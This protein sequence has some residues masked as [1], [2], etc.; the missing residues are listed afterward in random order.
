M[1]HAA[2]ASLKGCT[3][4]RLRRL[5]RRVTQH[6]D[7]WLAEA[8]LRVTQY[9]LLSMLVWSDGPTLSQLA[10]QMD[11]DRTTLTRNLRPLEAAG[12]VQLLPD[13]H[14]RRSRVVR[15]TPAGRTLWERAK[16]RWRAAQDS[17]NTALGT[18]Q[19]G[20]LHELLDA[21]LRRLRE[22]AVLTV[23]CAV[24]PAAHGH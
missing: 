13:E 21:S 18:Q 2:S 16:P 15:L 7:G 14:D 19:V 1:T 4:F 10:E 24:A 17:L 12:W 9:S 6:Y 22:Q 23:D 8:G 3:C 11:M 5:S 20:Q